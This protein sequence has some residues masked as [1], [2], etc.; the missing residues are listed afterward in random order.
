MLLG[1]SEGP[2][3]SPRRL[4]LH[5]TPEPRMGVAA[6]Q[7]NPPGATMPDRSRTSGELLLQAVRDDLDASLPAKRGQSVQE[8]GLLVEAVR[9]GQGG[10]AGAAESVMG[11]L[12][13]DLVQQSD[14]IALFQVQREHQVRRGPDVTVGM[15]A[16]PRADQEEQRDADAGPLQ[17]G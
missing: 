8:P 5:P 6:F 15:F 14:E 13:P 3:R 17:V 12:A 4:P 9:I 16:P 10:H 7:K 2:G 1:D 11:G